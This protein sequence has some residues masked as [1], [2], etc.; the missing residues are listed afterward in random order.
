[1][2]K[3]GALTGLLPYLENSFF[4]L[5]QVLSFQVSVLPS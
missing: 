2:A 3:K 5:S 4:L 1:M